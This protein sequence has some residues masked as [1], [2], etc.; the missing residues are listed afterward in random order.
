MS[1]AA[2]PIARLDGSAL[3]AA[4]AAAAAHLSASARAIDAIN[5]YPV[6]DGD[7]G[8][9]MSATLREAVSHAMGAGEQPTVAV[10]LAAL[11]R[12][13]LYG[14][15]GNSGV[16]LSQA[17]RGFAVSAGEVDAFDVATLARALAGAADAAYRAVSEP[18]EGT[19]LTVLRAA[20]DAAAGGLQAMD[21][22]GVGEPCAP[23]LGHVVIAA[24]AAERETME[25][26][27]ALKEAQVPDAG[28]EGVCVILRGLLAAIL[29]EAPVVEVALGS[30][31]LHAVGEEYGQCTEFLI[32]QTGLPLD[33]EA[34]RV[35]AA[36]GGGRSIVVVGDG[37]MAHVHVHSDAPS[38][39]IERAATAGRV[40]R[41]K[42]EDMGAQNRRF[43]ASGSGAGVRVAV[44]AFS[45]G[46][47]FDAIFA[48][49][50]ARTAELSAIEKPSAGIIAEAV[51]ALAIPDIIVL[52]NHANVI[53]AAN[54]A[55]G[56]ARATVHVVPTVSAAQGVAACIE[57]DPDRPVAENV[58]TMRAAIAHVRTVE[59]THAAASRTVNGVAVEEGQSIALVD[60]E[61]VAAGASATAALT[62]GVLHAAGAGTSLVTIYGGADCDHEELEQA[63]A[64]V[65]RSMPGVEVEAMDGGQR[66]YQFIASVE[67]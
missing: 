63:R 25:Q 51:D 57:F 53:F 67:T 11:A 15:R 49:L 13:S 62:A 24:E 14:A 42:V 22:G 46:P 6:P 35:M 4:F 47:G 17:L 31:V 5:V 10:V 66:L 27:P 33:L 65:A 43:A 60:G 1:A 16:I 36:A 55:V 48:G 39:V 2:G 8:A 61:L 44:L 7:T 41:V 34:L 32:E 54:Q 3:R 64:E 56:L 20:A 28:G 26:L 45:N 38:A 37:S 23:L 59:V 19:M 58:E 18:K 21:G 40:S 52:P 50:G 29:G 30:P 12:G 9:N